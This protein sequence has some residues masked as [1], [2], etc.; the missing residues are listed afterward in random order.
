[1]AIEWRDTTDHRAHRT[2]P[3]PLRL[4]AHMQIT[5]LSHQT[6]QTHVLYSYVIR[7]FTYTMDT[8]ELFYELFLEWT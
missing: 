3:Y 1:M 7:D 8:E 2:A 6:E 4:N 5:G